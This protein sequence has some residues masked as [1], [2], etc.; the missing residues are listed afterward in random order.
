MAALLKLLFFP[1]ILFGS[2]FHPPNMWVILPIRQLDATA[3]SGTIPE[4]SSA[5]EPFWR[6]IASATLAGK[7][8]RR[9]HHAT[10]AATGGSLPTSST[11][12]S[13]S[14]VRR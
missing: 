11:V 5:V 3:R 13:A 14:I 12:T 8:P 7:R 4:A 2:T 9:M 6:R 1:E 10:A